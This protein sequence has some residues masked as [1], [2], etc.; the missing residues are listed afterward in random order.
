[1]CPAAWM[2]ISMI[3][4]AMLYDK[5]YLSGCESTCVSLGLRAE[6]G[7]AVGPGE[8]LTGLGVSI[9]VCVHKSLYQQLE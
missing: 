5:T 3:Q 4:Y 8:S 9:C 2:N 1:M 7:L 6:R